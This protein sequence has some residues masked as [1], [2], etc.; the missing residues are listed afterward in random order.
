MI[1]TV[2]EA[3][4]ANKSVLECLAIR[5]EHAR[6]EASVIA[7]FGAFAWVSVT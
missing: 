2:P 3:V 6:A 5:G 1:L 7:A 4:S